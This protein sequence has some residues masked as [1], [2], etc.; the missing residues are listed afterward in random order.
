MN[1]L[2]CLPQDAVFWGEDLLAAALPRLARHGIERPMIFTVEPLQALARSQV[3]PHLADIAGHV[4]DL[5]A[6]VP[7][8]AV[9]AAL[10][11]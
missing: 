3:E 8:V 9:N 6:H 10:E 7:D 2:N 4:V 5:P 1:H 11:A